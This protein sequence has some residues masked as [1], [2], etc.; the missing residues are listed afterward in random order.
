MKKKIHNVFPFLCYNSLAPTLA[1][2]NSTPSPVLFYSVKSNK[3]HKIVK[4][5]ILTET[6]SFLRKQKNLYRIKFFLEYLSINLK[7]NL[8]TNFVSSLNFHNDVDYMYREL[9]LIDILE[10]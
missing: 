10:D 3:C 8:N 5:M 6:Q 1:T 2:L 7:A 9:G 4:L